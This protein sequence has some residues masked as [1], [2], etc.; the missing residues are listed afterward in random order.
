VSTSS[1]VPE[2]ATLTPDEAVTHLQQMRDQVMPML[3]AVK[4]EYE[5]RVRPGY[6]TMVDNV[7]HG[8]VFGLNLDPGF[9]LYFMTDGQEIY[10]ELHYVSLRTDTLSNANYEK[11][12]GS[13]IQDRREIDLNG[14]FQQYRNLVSQLLNRWQNQQT[15]VYRVDS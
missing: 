11:F 10:A 3:E 15:F 1:N 14:P 8:G 13:P 2:K 5:D 6:P 12:A 7:E 4:Q 9:G